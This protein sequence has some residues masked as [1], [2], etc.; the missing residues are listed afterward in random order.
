[1]GASKETLIDA[2]KLFVRSKLETAVPLWAGALT[3]KDKNSIERVQGNAV[4]IILGKN[5]TSYS[6]ELRNLNMDS[7]K[8]RRDKICLKFAKKCTKNEKFAHWFPK[9]SSK[10]TR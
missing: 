1:M 10:N 9:K 4:K 7:L 5:Y 6:Q 8:V 2:I 3:E